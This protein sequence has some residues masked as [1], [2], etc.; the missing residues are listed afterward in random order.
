MKTSPLILF[1]SYALCVSCVAQTF[2]AILWQQTYGGT[3][4]DEMQTMIAVPGGGYLLGGSSRS[5]PSGNKTARHWGWDQEDYWVVMVDENGTTL[6]DKGFGGDSLDG[7]A[8]IVPTRDGGYLF[9]GY[10]T[11]PRTV[12]WGGIK[13]APNYGDPFTSDMW[14]VKVD[15]E[16]TMLWDRAYGGTG[17]DWFAVILPTGDGGC[18]LAG[19]SSSAVGGTKTAPNYGGDDNWVVGIDADGNQLWDRSYGGSGLDSLNAAITVGSDGVLLVGESDS[20]AGPGKSAP[21]LGRNDCWVVRVGPDGAKR[22]DHSY[23]GSQINE[24][25]A[26]TPTAD[27][28]VLLGGFSN[29]L[30]SGN[31]AAPNRGG[32]DYWIVKIDGDGMKQWDQAYGGSSAD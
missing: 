14:L 4:R 3:D 30:A 17:G 13:T 9:G 32:S 1:G 31:K 23:G 25:W 10:S 19:T 15:A 28:G 18:V 27:G 6:W 16:G 12:E 5:R 8:A 2:P 20:P 26:A 21:L 29:S 24:A 7:L 11:S 22:W